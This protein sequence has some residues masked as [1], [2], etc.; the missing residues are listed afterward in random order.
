[1]ADITVIHGTGIMMT[2]GVITGATATIGTTVAMKAG[3]LAHGT[4]VDPGMAV[5]GMRSPMKGTVEGTIAA[6]P[7]WASNHAQTIV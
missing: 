5:A 1:M 3:R 4:A 2:T 6:D 7:A